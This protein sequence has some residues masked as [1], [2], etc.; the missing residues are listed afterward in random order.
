MTHAHF[1]DNNRAEECFD[2]LISPL[3]EALGEPEFG[4][5]LIT[6][7]NELALVDFFSVYQ[8]ST[9]QAPQMFLSASRKGRD[10]SDDCFQPYQQRLHRQDHTFDAATQTKQHLPAI[11]YTHNSQFPPAHRAAIYSRHDIQDRVSVVSRLN[12]DL[13]VATNFYRFNHQPAFS[14]NDL[15]SIQGITRS[16]AN[17]VSKHI[18]LTILSQKASTAP[19]KVLKKQL[20]E[21]YPQLSPRELELCQGLL[22]GQTYE[23][24][25][26]NMGVTLATVKTYRMRAFEKLEINFRS[27]LFSLALALKQPK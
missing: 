17:C 13:V 20:A 8:I 1:P 12:D 7:I 25:A 16:L 2:S 3:I 26:A 11:V 18:R 23:G 10:V 15:D 27:Q 21:H 22:L 24:I 4:S 5:H 6:H 9:N 19:M 14:D